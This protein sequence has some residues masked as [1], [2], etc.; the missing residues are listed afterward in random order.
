MVFA[1]GLAESRARIAYV[2]R[3]LISPRFLRNLERPD[4]G[5][6]RDEV[7]IEYERIMLDKNKD[8]ATVRRLWNGLRN[9]YDEIKTEG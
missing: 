8:E 1:F 5:M 3:T 4:E 9:I 6:A 2:Y 7:V